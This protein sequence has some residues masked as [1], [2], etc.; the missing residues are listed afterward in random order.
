M[1]VFV[2]EG[3]REGGAGRAAEALP[4]FAAVAGAGLAITRLLPELALTGK[5]ALELAVAGPGAAPGFSSSYRTSRTLAAGTEARPPN[6]AG[7]VLAG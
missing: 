4:E 6:F 7:S 5:L 2:E 1:F 3:A